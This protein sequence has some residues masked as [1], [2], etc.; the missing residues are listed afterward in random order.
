[1]GKIKKKIIYFFFWGG[2]G[3][4]GG[5]AGRGRGVGLGGGQGEYERRIEVFGKIHTKKYRG[6]QLGVVLG[7]WG[8]RV[9]VIAM[10]GVGVMWVWGM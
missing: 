7:W 9:D 5:G 8:V 1:M 10:F 6:A 4:R 2:G 3:G